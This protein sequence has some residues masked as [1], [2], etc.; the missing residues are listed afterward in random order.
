MPDLSDQFFEWT[1]SLCADKERRLPH[2]PDPLV[3][4]R[5]RIWAGEDVTTSGAQPNIAAALPNWADNHRPF[6]PWITVRLKTHQETSETDSHPGSGYT[7]CTCCIRKTTDKES[8]EASDATKV[9]AIVPGHLLILWKSRSIDLVLY[10]RL[11]RH[12]ELRSWRL[13]V[14]FPKFIHRCNN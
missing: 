8:Q 11:I 1:K 10:W 4:R 3:V 7:C 6:H 5:V 12:S 14:T 9:T 2:F 13:S